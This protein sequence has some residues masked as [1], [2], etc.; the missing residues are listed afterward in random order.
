MQG[1]PL[2]ALEVK[3]AGLEGEDEYQATLAT[4]AQILEA[5]GYRF[6]TVTMPANAK[7]PLYSN[8][9]LL[10]KAASRSDLWPAP[11]VVERIEALGAHGPM[12]LRMLC[13]ELDISPNLVPALLV[14]G[15][16][17]ADLTR[18]PIYADMDLALAFGDVG[19]LVLL[20]RFLR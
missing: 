9:P 18:H 3:I 6:A 1:A 10:K 12:T 8:L 17:G 15:A 20:D 2:N 16:V 5:A 7:H 13:R 19:H 11:D 14:S 4:A